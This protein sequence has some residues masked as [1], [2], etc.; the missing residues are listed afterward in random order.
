MTT[1]YEKREHNPIKSKHPTT[2][3]PDEK[4]LKKELLELSLEPT[5]ENKK[6]REEIIK[7][8]Q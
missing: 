7:L 5:K 1:I 6:R 8:L 3:T 2:G 4:K